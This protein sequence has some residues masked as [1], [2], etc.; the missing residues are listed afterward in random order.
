MGGGRQRTSCGGGGVRNVRYKS[1]V[2][3]P[4]GCTRLIWPNVRV[5]S[6]C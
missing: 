6:P 2:L 3:F 4:V 5:C 1:P